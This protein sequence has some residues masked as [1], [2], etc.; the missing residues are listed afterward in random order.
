M[1][2]TTNTIQN[3]PSM[4]ESVEPPTAIRQEG[5]N[6]PSDEQMTPT[7]KTTKH[8]DILVTALTLGWIDV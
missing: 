1:L 8:F 6:K 4:D 7:T 3:N 5:N 2:T